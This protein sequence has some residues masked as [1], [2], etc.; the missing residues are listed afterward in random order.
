MFVFVLNSLSV[1]EFVGVRL[2]LSIVV[3]VVDV[4]SRACGCV[5]CVSAMCSRVFLTYVCDCVCACRDV[6]GCILC[7]LLL[8]M[9]CCACLCLWLWLMCAHSCVY[10]TS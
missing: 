4:C 2:C 3:F 10:V 7:V 5:S 6:Q 1:F 9:Y 8:L